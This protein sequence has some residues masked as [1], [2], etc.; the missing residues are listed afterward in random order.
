[1]TVTEVG[2]RFE[3]GAPYVRLR[4][5]TSFMSVNSPVNQ[6]QMR[7]QTVA[8]CLSI[9]HNF[10]VRT[11]FV[12]Q[13]IGPSVVERTTRSECMGIRYGENL[14]RAVNYWKTRHR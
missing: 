10:L 7:F 5:P 13:L 9:T 4:G 1:M 14:R 2:Y 3:H 11:L 8:A 6:L 12:S